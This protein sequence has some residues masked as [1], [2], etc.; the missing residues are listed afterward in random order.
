MS[1]RSAITLPQFASCYRSS[2]LDLIIIFIEIIFRTSSS[3]HDMEECDGRE[4]ERKHDNHAYNC[5]SNHQKDFFC[6]REVTGV[7]SRCHIVSI[8]G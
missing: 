5:E 6:R 3:V 1:L 2:N 7:A 8:E 4:T